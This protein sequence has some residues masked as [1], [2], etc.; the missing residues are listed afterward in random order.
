MDSLAI[1]QKY[2]IPDSNL[3][4]VLISHSND[5]RDLALEFVRRRPDLHMDP[6]FV[7]DAAMLHD[8][9]IFKTDAPSIYCLGKE[10]YIRHGY[11]GAE[12]MRAE[13]SPAIALVCERHTGTGLS[14]DYI[15]RNNLPVPHHD[16]LPVSYEEQVICFADKFFSKSHLG[17][18]RSASEARLKLEKFG[19]DTLAR[20]DVWCH[21]FNEF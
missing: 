17:Y 20:F 11:L 3:Y 16:M 21:M 4:R 18:R 1:I 2:Y 14:L 7:S 5:V 19:A 10:P 15:L 9:G 6:Q 13:G 12:L 8:I